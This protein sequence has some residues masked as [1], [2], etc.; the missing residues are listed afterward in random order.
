MP[1]STLST[2][3]KIRIKIRRIT[4]SPSVSQ[5]TDDQIDD[6]INTFILYDLP[7]TL[8]LNTL[9]QT[10]TFYTSSNIDTYSTNT[11]DATDPLYNFKNKYSSIH[12]PVYVAWKES[13]LSLSEEEFYGI[14]PKEQYK[15]DIGTGDGVTTNF[16]G[17]LDNVPILQ[18]N[19]IISSIDTGGDPL[20][21]FDDGFGTLTG[22]VSV[23]G[24]IVY[25]VGTYDVD[26]DI[27]PESGKTVWIQFI[28]YTADKPDTILFKNNEF[29]LRPVPDGTYAIEVQ[30]FIRPTELSNDSDIPELAEWWQYIAYG[31]AIKLFQDRS[32]FESINNIAGEFDRQET[33]INRRTIVQNSS[34]RAATIYS[35]GVE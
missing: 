1:D 34:K 16:T 21:V 33:L 35:D 13:F 23:P 26:F 24:T 14:Y 30:G 29:I 6:Y 12:G 19:V 15:V 9:N 32:D 3:E 4:R 2:L 8:K 27:A 20:Q 31:A 5:I 22:D 28:P 7:A 18:N 17:T 25:L 10:L 11:V